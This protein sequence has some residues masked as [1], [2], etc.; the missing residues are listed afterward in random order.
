MARSHEGCDDKQHIV[1]GNTSLYQISSAKDDSMDTK[2]TPN[3]IYLTLI[4]KVYEGR[5]DT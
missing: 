1:H 3:F 5:D 4:S 2:M